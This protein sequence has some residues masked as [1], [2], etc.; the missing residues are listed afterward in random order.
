[1]LYITSKLI[2]S[3]LVINQYY[4]PKYNITMVNY[5]F[6]RGQLKAHK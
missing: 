2:G 1:M 5:S 4:H 3:Q 6:G